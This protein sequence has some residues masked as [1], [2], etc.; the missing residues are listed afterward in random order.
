[1]KSK[2][3]AKVLFSWAGC[4]GLLFLLSSLPGQAA[5]A[6]QANFNPGD[7]VK[8]IDNPYF[9]LKPGEVFIYSG[10][11]D[12]GSEVLQIIVS[13]QKKTI[14]GVEC[15]IVNET[16]TADGILTE[17]SMNWYA[18]DKAGNVWYFGE[19]SKE[20][21]NGEVVSTEGS[22]E[23]GVNGAEQGIMMEAHP[24]VGDIYYQE[25]APGVAMDMAQVLSKEKQVTVPYREFDHCLFTKESTPLEPDVVEYKYYARGVGFIMAKMEDNLRLKLRDV[26]I[27]PE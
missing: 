2:R 16:V 11:T 23:A 15:M 25:I 14:L 20:Y 27:M 12:E 5:E 9:P 24:R 3:I 21:E 8:V 18:Q 22:W 26:F 1:V 6:T 17:V 19:D 4:L 7:F 13:H 10:M